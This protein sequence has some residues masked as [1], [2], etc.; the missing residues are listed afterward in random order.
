MEQ[1]E[2]PILVAFNARLGD[3]GP[4]EFGIAASRVT[5]AP[6]VIQWVHRGGEEIQD[7]DARALQRLREDLAQRGLRADVRSV[8]GWSIGVELIEAAARLGAQMIVLGTTRRGAA[9]AALLGT[10][11]ERVIHQAGC[12]V[13][14]VPRDYE[15]PQAGIATVGIAYAPA[16]EAR[17]ALNWAAGLARAGALRLRV[18]QAVEAAEAAAAEAALRA[19]AGDAEVEVAVADPAAALLAAAHTVDLL[20]MGSRGRGSPR[21]VSLGSVSRQ[22]AERAPCPVLILPRGTDEAARDLLS[23]AQAQS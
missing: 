9:Q 16:P 12:P 7:D 6:L 21:Q 20:V 17:F 10:T 13:A 1:H 5:A 18:I 3:R 11:V 22:V 14:V 19:Q 4:V 23:H 15:H 2:S 8:A